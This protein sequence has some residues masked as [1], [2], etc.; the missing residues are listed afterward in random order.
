MQMFTDIAP[1][2][3]P[4]LKAGKQKENFCE[5]QVGLPADHALHD[6]YRVD[7]NLVVKRHILIGEVHMDKSVR[8]GVAAQNPA[9]MGY[10][11]HIACGCVSKK[12]HDK[13]DH[14]HGRK[15]IWRGRSRV[16]VQCQ[17][18]NAQRAAKAADDVHRAQISVGFPVLL[19]CGCI[20][21]KGAN[22]NGRY[23]KSNMDDKQGIID[24]VNAGNKLRRYPAID[25]SQGYIDQEKRQRANDKRAG[26]Q[27]FQIPRHMPEALSGVTNNVANAVNDFVHYTYG[28]KS[29]D[30]N[31][32][33]PHSACRS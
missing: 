12:G 28:I 25:I 17:W 15:S 27:I 11:V 6:L 32:S 3:E 18:N 23:G 33:A 19:S 5:H 9:P 1:T 2:D 30:L 24:P 20:N 26:A 21:H 29:H 10:K 31:Y 16:V 8:H 4:P 7:R 14:R 13:P 22:D